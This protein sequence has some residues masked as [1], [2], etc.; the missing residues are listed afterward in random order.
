M[1]EIWKDITGYEGLYQVSNLGRIKSLKRIAERKN[2]RCI[3]VGGI[4]LKPSR[5]NIGYLFVVP[6]K[7]GVPHTLYIHKLVANAFIPNPES[8]P[9][10]N[11]ING[12]KTDNKVDNLEWCTQSE[13]IKHSFK[14]LG[15]KKHL[16]GKFSKEHPKSKTVC[17]FDLAGRFI[18][19]W[20]SINDA[21]NELNI[22]CSSI[23]KCCLKNR[24]KA[25]GYIWKYKN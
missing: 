3:K 6:R 2:S 13:N 11:H 14:T 22:D 4:I 7:N 24:N 19:E 16:I 20:D 10:V 23:S 15:H 12:V 8:K 18:K 9:Q 5:S 21:S 25:G 17:Q 1:E